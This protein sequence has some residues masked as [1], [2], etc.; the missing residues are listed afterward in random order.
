MSM[1][2]TLRDRLRGRLAALRP[3]QHHEAGAG[4]LAPPRGTMAPDASAAQDAPDAPASHVPQAASV[5]QVSH[6]PQAAS[7]RVAFEDEIFF[8][9]RHERD[10]A[11]L[12]AFGGLGVALVL[13]FVLAHAVPARTVE[14]YVVVVDAATAEALPTRAV[15]ARPLTISGG[16]A[17]EQAL[18]HD[19]VRDR[20]TYDP[21]DNDT[22]IRAVL[23]RSRGEARASLVRLWSADNPGYPPAR[24]GQARIAAAVKSVTLLEPGLARVRYV[25]SRRDGTKTLTRALVAT[26]RFV[27]E[28]R[29]EPSM[30]ALW[31]NPLG[32]AVTGWRVDAE[33][34]ETGDSP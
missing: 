24:H 14:P 23:A 26:V 34:L 27:L 25:R 28:P 4:T 22:R 6:T 32:F 15:A 7:A 20:E 12:L 29:E 9:L 8:R 1:I 30:A 10:R 19:Y 3:R 2:R 13:A 18:V 21:M 5:P 33:A 11:V 31:A 16:D 17:L